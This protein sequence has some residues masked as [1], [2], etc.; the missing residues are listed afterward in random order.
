MTGGVSFFIPEAPGV[1]TPAQYE[2]AAIRHRDGRVTGELVL[3]VSRSTEQF[4]WGDIVCFSTVGKTAFLAAKIRKTN[5]SFLPPEA[6][7][8]WTVV[9]NGEGKKDAPDQT[10]TFMTVDEHLARANC[11]VGALNL[12]VFPVVRG[13]IQVHESH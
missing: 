10:S 5:V 7:F 1:N 11:D 9:D 12:A 6:Y 8:T 3:R 4:F 2:M 13:N